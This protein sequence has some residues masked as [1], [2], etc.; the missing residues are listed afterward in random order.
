M[1]HILSRKVAAERVADKDKLLVRP[2][3]LLLPGCQTINEVID[4]LLVRLV[5]PFGSTTEAIARPVEEVQTP[6]KG[7]HQRFHDLE[8]KPRTSR[9]PVHHHHGSYF[10]TVAA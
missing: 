2:E 4:G 10:V 5:E 7:P 9:V 6:C 8:V 3:D 1:T